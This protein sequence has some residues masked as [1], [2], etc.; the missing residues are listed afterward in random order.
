LK[1]ENDGNTGLITMQEEQ[2]LLT[3]K[4][5]F[6]V[7]EPKGFNNPEMLRKHIENMECIR[8]DNLKYIK[9]LN[10]ESSEK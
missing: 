5:S 7:E 1:K 3:N 9:E 4:N 10:D 8:V 2:K 6:H